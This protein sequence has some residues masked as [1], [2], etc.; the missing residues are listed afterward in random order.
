MREHGARGPYAWYGAFLFDTAVCERFNRGAAVVDVCPTLRATLV[1]TTA[2]TAVLDLTDEQV[3][4]T[5][6]AAPE[7]GEVRDET[8][9]DLTQRWARHL[10][11]VPGVRGLRYWSARQ[12]GP[13]DRRHGANVVLWRKRALARPAHQH[14]LIDDALWP[15]VLVALDRA[16][17]AVNRVGACPRC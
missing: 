13:D 11:R 16:G 17:V 1:G 4:A 9:Y 6:G 14:R 5:L 3:C 2:D 8:V 12:R 15:H 7:L 10:H